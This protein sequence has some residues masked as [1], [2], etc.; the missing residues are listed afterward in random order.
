MSGCKGLTIFQRNRL[1]HKPYGGTL[2]R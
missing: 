1:G 2:Y